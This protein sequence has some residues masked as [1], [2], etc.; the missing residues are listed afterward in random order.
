[1]PSGFIQPKQM[2]NILWD[3]IRAQALSGEISRKDSSV[4]EIAETKALTQKVF[5]IHN[6]TTAEFDKSY[7]WYTNHPEVLRLLFDS[8]NAQRQR[9]NEMKLK[10]MREPLKLDSNKKIKVHE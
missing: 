3:V 2:Q 1:M 9:D 5:Q 10:I 4:N 6:I 7:A 8:L